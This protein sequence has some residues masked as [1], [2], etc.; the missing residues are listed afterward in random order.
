MATTKP[1]APVG[2]A[3]AGRATWSRLVSSYTF[4]PHE[5]LVAELVA[6]QSDD[7]ARLESLLEEQGLV[8]AGSTGR[9][10]LSPVLG[11]LRQARLAMSKLLGAI[12]LPDEDNQPMSESSRRASKAAKAR[13][14]HRA[15]V[16][17]QRRNLGA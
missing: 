6:K 2:L 11:E 13:W 9:P 3:R 12:G 16:A 15:D 14:G 8:I 4:L 10:R 5:L 1:K 7:I 17:G